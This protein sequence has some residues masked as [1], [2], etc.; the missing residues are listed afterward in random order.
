M[1]L[2][3]LSTEA[4]SK[5]IKGWSM[6]RII[7]FVFQNAINDSQANKVIDILLSLT[8]DDDFNYTLPNN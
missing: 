2:C 8:E 4:E 7:D 3:K 1:T 5:L 6:T